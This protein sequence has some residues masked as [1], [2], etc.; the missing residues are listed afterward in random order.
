[1]DFKNITWVVQVQNSF[2]AAVSYSDIAQR[3]PGC[4]GPSLRALG[5]RGTA[6]SGTALCHHAVEK[7]LSLCL[8]GEGTWESQ[9]GKPN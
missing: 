2:S 8:S 3:F 5:A 9:V 1:M 7:L 4:R 6:G